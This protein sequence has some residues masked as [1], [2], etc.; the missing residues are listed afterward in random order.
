VAV[1]HLG[2]QI[3]HNVCCV[4]YRVH[5]MIYLLYYCNYV[6]VNYVTCVISWGRCS[7][8]GLLVVMSVVVLLVLPAFC[9]PS[10]ML[11]ARSHIIKNFMVIFIVIPCNRSGHISY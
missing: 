5:N 2:S 10:M 8:I 7:L 1:S 11:N 6:G 3:A 9:E 4:S